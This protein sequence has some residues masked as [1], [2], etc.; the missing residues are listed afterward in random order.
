MR[1]EHFLPSHCQPCS[2]DTSCDLTTP[3]MARTGPRIV[4][5]T[6]EGRILIGASLHRWTRQYGPGAGS[7]TSFLAP[8]RPFGEAAPGLKPILRGVGTFRLREPRVTP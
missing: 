6:K 7:S 2:W 1:R 3:G 8:R 4:M 5:M